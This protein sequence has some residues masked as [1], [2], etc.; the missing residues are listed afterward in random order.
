[1]LISRRNAL[2]T[3]LAGSAAACA[4]RPNLGSFTAD[5]T[6]GDGT[7]TSGVASGDPAADS[8][9]LWTRIDGASR[10]TLPVRVEV[11]EDR[12]F[13]TVVWSAN[14]ET[15]PE[16]DFTVKAI[17]EGLEPGR[18]Y[19]YRFMVYDR[20]SPVGMTRTLPEET[21]RV[22][23]AVMSCS[24]FNFG[25]FNAYDHAARDTRIDA[26]VH[27][28]DY[29][30]EYGPDGYGG[31]KGAE[32]GRPHDP[33][34]ELVTLD[35]YRRRHR[36]YKNDPATRRLHAAHPI[37]AVWDDHE[38]SNDSFQKGAENHQPTAEGGWEERKRAALQAYYEYMPVREPRPGR[39][40]EELFKTYS[41]GKFLSLPIIESRLTARDEQVSYAEA[42]PSLTS[43]EAVERFKREVLGDPARELLGQAQ[44]AFLHDALKSSVDRGD[45]WRVIGNQVMM[46]R[47]TSPD[48]APFLTEADIVSFEKLFP[49]LR[50]FLAL[51][52]L[53]LPL[54]VD[55]WDGYPAAR[56][57]LFQ[58]ATDVGATDLVVLTGDSHQ[59]WA[60]DLTRD[61]GTPMGVELGT[62]GITSPGASAYLGERAFDVSL[63]LR[64]DNPDVRYTDPANQG[65]IMLEFKEDTA[66]AQFVS[67]STIEQPSYNAI[68]TASFNLKKENGTVAF[69]G[70]QGLGFKERV[71][72]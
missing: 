16:R 69:D 7:F 47:V 43:P 14:L 44:Q 12:S 56:E 57:R 1:M 34:R 6:P 62:T 48:L 21:D 22:R 71:L 20:V 50:A 5:L 27:L 33:P 45:T 11:A 15:G 13:T 68:Q 49:D 39:S 63:L 72:F 52:Q 29:I 3:G 31:A 42:V 32:L 4:T 35:D 18:Q 37:I 59:F 58:N 54:N 60:N 46:A 8:V 67:M 51:G 24:N 36:Q 65:Y 23:L 10:G 28:G 66:R 40:R 38:T 53:G 19:A 55:A 30:Y 70:F 61:D 41:W 64:R 26:V 2:F 9:V 17:A 25:Y